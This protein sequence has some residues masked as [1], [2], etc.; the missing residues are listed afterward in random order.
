MLSFKECGPLFF[1]IGFTDIFVWA[2]D[3]EQVLYEDYI[4]FTCIISIIYNFDSLTQK[5]IKMQV[6]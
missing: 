6:K 5:D 2:I 4:V 1:V 3:A